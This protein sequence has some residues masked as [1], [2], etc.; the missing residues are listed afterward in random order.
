MT[1][2][3]INTI[4]PLNWLPPS[5]FLYLIQILLVTKTRIHVLFHERTYSYVYGNK[6]SLTLFNFLKRV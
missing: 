2:R 1:M 4:Q 5:N 6:I 3:F